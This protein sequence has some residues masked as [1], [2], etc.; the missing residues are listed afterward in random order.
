MILQGA[1]CILRAVEPMDIELLYEW[2]NNISVWSV[3]GTTTPFSRHTLS[4]FVEEQQFDIYQT[5]QQRLIIETLDHVAVGAIDL[6]EF[7]PL[8]QRI[9]IGILIHEG[10]NRGRGYACDA[11]E[12]VCRYAREY[13]FAHQLWCN[14]GGNNQ[15]SIALFTKLGFELIGI[16][17]GWNITIEGRE[18]EMMFQKIL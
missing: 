2:E 13:L 4:R 8:N 12:V 16:K 1:I 7:D 11:L 17:K 18:D 14:I 5:K 9:G 10:V 15:A 6:F 3:S